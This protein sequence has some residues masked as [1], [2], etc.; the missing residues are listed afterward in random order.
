M[1]VTRYFVLLGAL[2]LGSHLA[3]AVPRPG[4][5]GEPEIEVV[6]LE[7]DIENAP[8]AEAF[9]GLS[10]TPMSELLAEHLQVQG[11]LVIGLVADDSAAMDAGLQERDIL[12][13]VDGKAVASQEQLAALM[14][15]KAV[16]DEL[17]LSV[18]RKGEKIELTATAGERPAAIVNQ[19]PLR[20]GGQFPGMLRQFPQGA[21]GADAAQMMQELNERLEELHKQFDDDRFGRLFG[22][23]DLKDMRGLFHGFDGQPGISGSSSVSISD[24]KGSISIKDDGQGK[25]IT[26]RDV[27]GDVVYQG[28]YETDTD[29]AAVPEGVAERLKG[30]QMNGVKFGLR[31][32]E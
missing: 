6:E 19:R 4:G 30:V 16:G 1:K 11:G 3:I 20:R 7:Q 28:P 32:G 14:Q 23:Q 10:G 13:A 2:A 9:L 22:D 26:V 29:K 17:T 27:D 8:A 21:G 12:I 15:T 5:S 24:N 25:V 31:A 18:I